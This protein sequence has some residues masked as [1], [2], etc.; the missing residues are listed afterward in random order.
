MS[1]VDGKQERKIRDGNDG[2]D[3]GLS[4]VADE[5]DI[6]MPDGTI[7]KGYVALGDPRNPHAGELLSED[8]EKRIDSEGAEVVKGIPW[9]EGSTGL[10]LVVGAA[11]G[12]IRLDRKSPGASRLT[13][14][15]TITKGPNLCIS[16]GCT[17]GRP[18]VLEDCV[19]ACLEL[20]VDL[21][22]DPHKIQYVTEWISHSAIEALAAYGL[23][24][25]MQVSGFK[26]LAV[27]V[28]KASEQAIAAW[29][30]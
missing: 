6:E 24:W 19:A 3:R 27:A 12:G 16:V 28:A 21:A 2:E 9:S 1:N 11:P 7:K 4:H 17:M 22:Q 30:L 13:V 8:D 25:D 5:F 29:R 10:Y 20:P 18:T 23:K 26:E 14:P 15:Q